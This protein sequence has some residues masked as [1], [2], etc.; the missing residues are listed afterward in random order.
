VI[1]KKNSFVYRGKKTSKNAFFLAGYDELLGEGE[2]VFEKTAR[3][4]C[5]LWCD[6]RFELEKS[7]RHDIFWASIV[8]RYDKIDFYYKI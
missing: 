6:I 2:G 1:I 4:A 5:G 3:L 7:N 8:S